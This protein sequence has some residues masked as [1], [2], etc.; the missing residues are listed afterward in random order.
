ML[1]YD[2]FDGLNIF[3]LNGGIDFRSPTLSL[4]NS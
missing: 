2:L 3:K 4:D 1:L